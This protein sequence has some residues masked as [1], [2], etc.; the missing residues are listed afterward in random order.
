[1]NTLQIFLTGFETSI[2]FSY[3]MFYTSFYNNE[4]ELSSIS[5]LGEGT[6]LSHLLKITFNFISLG[7]DVP[8]H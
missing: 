6:V 1:L 3:P 5:I 4:A 7:V 2:N 8:L